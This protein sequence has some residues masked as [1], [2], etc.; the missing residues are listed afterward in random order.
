MFHKTDHIADGCLSVSE[1]S[2]SADLGENSTRKVVR[3]YASGC[4]QT[5]FL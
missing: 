1:N 3:F 4:F 5:L 2:R